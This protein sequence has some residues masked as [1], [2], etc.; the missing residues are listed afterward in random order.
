MHSHNKSFTS[1]NNEEIIIRAALDSD[2]S[3]LLNLKLSYLQTSETIPLTPSE[4]TNSKED[5]RALIAKYSASNNSILLVAVA[6][7]KIIGNIDITGSN[8]SRMAHTAMIGM[9]LSIDFRNHGIGSQLLK[10]AILWSQ[11]NKVLSLL[12]LEVYAVNTAAIKLYKNY[13]FKETGRVENF[14]K[15]CEVY[16]DKVTMKLHLNT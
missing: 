6:N 8:R 15:H 10:E 7:N 11:Q 5:E 16:Y 13:G 9:G 1:K 12:W 3:E 14:F 4:Y 2:V